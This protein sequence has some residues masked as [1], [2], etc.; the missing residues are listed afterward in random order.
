MYDLARVLLCNTLTQQQTLHAAPGHP[1]ARKSTGETADTLEKDGEAHKVINPLKRKRP[2]P[3]KDDS[4]LQEYLGLMTAPSKLKTWRDG[5]Q[6]AADIP[7][8]TANQPTQAEQTPPE[9]VDDTAVL[10]RKKPAALTS[11]DEDADIP[12]AVKTRRMAET[13]PEDDKHD[14]D[15][16]QGPPP[17]TSDMDWMR[18]RTSRLLG[19]V[20]DDVE[21]SDQEQ[22]KKKSRAVSPELEKGGASTKPAVEAN[23]QMNIGPN[24]SPADAPPAENK[25][26][27]NADVATI[28]KTGRLFLRNLA[29]TITE[30]EI[31]EYL[32]AFGSLEEVRNL[33]SPTTPYTRQQDECPDRDS[34]CY[35]QYDANW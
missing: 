28:R 34:L 7:D 25:E 4:K 8:S 29:Y 18:S 19:L 30:D 22:D 13:A 26:E 16:E 31:R 6:P 14:Q 32:S 1:T 9:T 17:G 24:A 23:A 35:Q 2:E 27:V 12:A 21:D 33:L 15:N 3:T 10:P 11:D 5:E 20:T